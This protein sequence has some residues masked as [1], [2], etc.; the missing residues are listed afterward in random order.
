MI[1]FA[2]ETVP[3]SGLVTVML[4]EPADAL[5]A[6]T[7][8]MVSVVEASV[9]VTEATV[10]PVPSK[11]AVALVWK[12]DPFTVTV[13]FR[14]V[15]ETPIDVPVVVVVSARTLVISTEVTVGGVVTVTCAVLVNRLAVP[16]GGV[17]H[18]YTTAV[19]A[20]ANVM[21]AL[22]PCAPVPVI[23]VDTVVAVAQS[24]RRGAVVFVPKFTAP[25]A[26]GGVVMVLP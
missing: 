1:A 2:N 13:R 20:L 7:S 26:D 17:L 24:A 11:A 23:A 19:P 18:A 10:R 5:A 14:C 9:R 21:D 16:P 8:E 6:I 22:K 12:F 4:R 15:A 25:I 3:P